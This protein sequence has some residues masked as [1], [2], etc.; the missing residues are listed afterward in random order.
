MLLTCRHYYTCPRQRHVSPYRRCTSDEQPNYDWRATKWWLTKCKQC[1]TVHELRSTEIRNDDQWLA[2]THHLS[3]LRWTY[4]QCRCD[5]ESVWVSTSFPIDLCT[6]S[7]QYYTYPIRLSV[8]SF[9]KKRARNHVQPFQS[10][11]AGRKH[12]QGVTELEKYDK[13]QKWLK[14]LDL[15]VHSSITSQLYTDIQN[16]PILEKTEANEIPEAPVFRPHA[17]PLL[18]VQNPSETSIIYINSVICVSDRVLVKKKRVQKKFHIYNRERILK[19]SGKN[20][21]VGSCADFLTPKDIFAADMYC[22]N[23]CFSKYIHLSSL[24]S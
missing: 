5:H 9:V 18:P 19:R 4:T 6:K 17:A 15:I 22:H 10:S 3:T 11:N 24:K 14:V 21:I 7:G 20:D 13:V 23:T 12:V 16:F 1:M 8:V 2:A